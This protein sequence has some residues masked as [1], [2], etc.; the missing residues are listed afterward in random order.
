MS[1]NEEEYRDNLKEF[2]THIFWAFWV[3]FWVGFFGFGFGL[4]F[5]GF[6]VWVYRPKPNPKTHLFL[7]TDH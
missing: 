4:G 1:K 7:G 3:G 2:K 6:W 5:L